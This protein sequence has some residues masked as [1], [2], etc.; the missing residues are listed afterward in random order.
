MQAPRSIQGKEIPLDACKEGFGRKDNDRAEK[1][2]RG[3]LWIL[4]ASKKKNIYWGVSGDSRFKM[5]LYM[6]TSIFPTEFGKGPKKEQGT[7]VA[8]VI[9]QATQARNQFSRKK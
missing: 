5:K 3:T 4:K 9:V 1:E 2:V 6:T 7:A 8:K